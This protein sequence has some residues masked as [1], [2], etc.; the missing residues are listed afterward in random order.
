MHI[1][2]L[3]FFY[4]Q[5]SCMFCLSISYTFK[6]YFIL[7]LNH[8]QNACVTIVAASASLTIVRS[9]LILPPAPHSGLI[10]ETFYKG[11]WK[12]KEKVSLLLANSLHVGKVC[13]LLL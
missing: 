11:D 10:S 2:L 13:N 3:Y 9:S 6:K 5:L 1:I 7:C 8:I 12:W 4:K